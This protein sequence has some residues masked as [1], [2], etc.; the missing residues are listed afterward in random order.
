LPGGAVNANEMRTTP[1]STIRELDHRV[2]DGIDVTL[3]WDPRTDQV[4]VAVH[5]GRYGESFQ[6]QVDPAEALDAFRH[7]YAYTRPSVDDRTRIA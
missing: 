4:L 2:S 1:S 3:F 7:P 6:L 5:D